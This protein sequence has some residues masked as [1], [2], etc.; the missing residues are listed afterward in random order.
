VFCT[1]A[2]VGGGIYKTGSMAHF[3]LLLWRQYTF[4]NKKCATLDG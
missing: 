2:K 3:V 1:P 4:D